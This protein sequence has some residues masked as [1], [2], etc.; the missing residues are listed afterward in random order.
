MADAFLGH[1]EAA[2]REARRSVELLPLTKDSVGGAL[3]LQ[4]LAMI[5]AWTGEKDLALENLEVA[6][7]TPGFVTYGKL[8]LESYWDPLRGDPRFDQIVASL[9]PK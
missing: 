4:Y 6:T 5:Y 7:R 2:I 8:R 9:A 3:V 1:K